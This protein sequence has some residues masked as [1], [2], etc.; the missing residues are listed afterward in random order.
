M[1][2]ELGC[3]VPRG[4]GP[5]RCAC[6][7]LSSPAGKDAGPAQIQQLGGP[8]LVWHRHAVPV[9]A[10]ALPESPSVCRTGQGGAEATLRPRQKVYISRAGEDN[11][12]APGKGRAEKPRQETKGNSS[13]VWDTEER[14]EYALLFVT[15]YSAVVSGK[16]YGA[17]IFQTASHQAGAGGA[18]VQPL[19]ITQ[20][21]GGS[22]EL[23]GRA[24]GLW[25]QPHPNRS[26]APCLSCDVPMLLSKVCES[27]RAPAFRCV[28]RHCW[29]TGLGAGAPRRPGLQGHR[30]EP[31]EGARP[32]S[33]PRKGAPS[34]QM[35]LLCKV[36][37]FLST[38]TP[39][40]PLRKM[41]PETSRLGV[42]YSPELLYPHRIHS[43]RNS[44]PRRTPN[45]STHPPSLFPS[46]TCSPSPWHPLLKLGPFQAPSPWAPSDY[47]AVPAQRHPGPSIPLLK[48]PR[49]LSRY[50]PL[51]STAPSG[52][53]VLPEK[54]N[55]HWFP[56]DQ[57]H[58]RWPPGGWFSSLPRS[59]PAPHPA[60]L[61]A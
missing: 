58:A 45:T 33:S 31:R 43:A 19:P 12:G 3:R 18:G 28:I 50:P 21:W 48:A 52:S 1:N 39:C 47:T 26:C 57:L 11:T 22:D 49:S 16:A 54:I 30:R 34:L 51:L 13:P 27:E 7:G 29:H 61:P 32:A 25:S 41:S 23:R 8:G 6:R 53:G 46:Q 17:S 55:N 9:G 38:Q 59:I 14:T 37:S 35:P 40:C 42:G 4:S 44:D 24:G 60:P 36:L 56:D 15:L 5:Q 20:R 2:E 10:Q